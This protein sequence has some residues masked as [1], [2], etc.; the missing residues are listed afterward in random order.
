M[1]IVHK[2]IKQPSYYFRF[3]NTYFQYT[4]LFVVFCDWESFY[5]LIWILDFIYVF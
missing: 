4:M 5:V 2:F 1:V 3:N